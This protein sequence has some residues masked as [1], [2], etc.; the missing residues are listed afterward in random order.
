MVSFSIVIPIHPPHFHYIPSLIDQ[1]NKFEG[2]SINEVIF[3]ASETTVNNFESFQALSKYQLIFS[4]VPYRCNASM[5]RNRG[6]SVATGDW[7]AFIDADDKY[8]PIK[9]KVTEDVILQHQ[10]ANCIIH[11][12][13]YHQK[14]F[15]PFDTENYEIVTNDFIKAN[16][17]TNGWVDKKNLNH[18]NGDTNVNAGNIAASQ[19]MTTV[20]RSMM[21]RYE[22][23]MNRGEDGYFCRKVCWFNDGLIAINVPL[24]IYNYIS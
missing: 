9:L 12:Y 10:N 7:I 2:V 17:F 22:E 15:Q 13:F 5:N 8:H 6:W 1:I 3:A 20:R 18:Y 14:N 16:T 21:Q 19:G 4:C 23:D 11:S 24:M